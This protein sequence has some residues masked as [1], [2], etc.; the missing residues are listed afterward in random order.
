[1]TFSTPIKQQT[2]KVVDGYIASSDARSAGRTRDRSSDIFN[3]GSLG[4]TERMTSGFGV[5]GDGAGEAGGVSAVGG[6]G[7]VGGG[8]SR[9]YRMESDIFNLNDLRSGLA[10]AA[11]APYGPAS[12]AEGQ[13][14]TGKAAAAAAAE[15]EY[16]LGSRRVADTY[17]DNSA[18]RDSVARE[19]SARPLLDRHDSTASMYPEDNHDVDHRN[20]DISPARYHH[21]DDDVSNTTPSRY[22]RDDDNVLD[23]TRD[24]YTSSSVLPPSEA[25]YSRARTPV[26]STT[27]YKDRPQ[28]IDRPTYDTSYEPS[29]PTTHTRR[30][31]YTS[32]P[33]TPYAIDDDSTTPSF[34]PPPPSTPPVQTPYA[35]D[36]Y[37]QVPL[38]RPASV[39]H[40]QT[41]YATTTNTPPTPPQT[42]T[43]TQRLPS[44]PFTPSAS[45]AKVSTRR[46]FVGV[47]TSDI[48]GLTPRGSLRGDEREREGWPD[49]GVAEGKRAGGLSSAEVNRERS[50]R[51]VG[52]GRGEVGQGMAGFYY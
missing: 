42:Y 10:S 16:E 8:S 37:G 25:P 44:A 51:G 36:T 30:P 19:K 34:F 38:P 17:R 48:F 11:A 14:G 26:E 7:G 9:R 4:R 1:M 41:P 29:T 2:P 21:H 23:T 3:L 22:L 35:T 5:V 43:A 40:L 27:T 33:R 15:S 18:G 50:G 13:Y 12:A 28:I 24:P 20:K 6:A 32:A 49:L 45:D 31:T 47:G 46:H 39:T 52:G